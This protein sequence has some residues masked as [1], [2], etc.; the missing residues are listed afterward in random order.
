MKVHSD[1]IQGSEDWFALR[2]GKVTGSIAH[3]VQAKGRGGG[4]SLTRADEMF[5]LALEIIHNRPRPAG[6]KSADMIH[7]TETEPFARSHY[8]I[9]EGVTVKEVGFITL[10]D[11]VGCSPDGLIGD[12]GLIEI[13]CP[14]NR[15]QFDRFSAGVFPKEYK[16]QVQFLLWATGRQWCDFVSFAPDMLSM[17]YFKIRV[18]RDPEYINTL[19]IAVEKFVQELKILVETIGQSPF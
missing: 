10:G 14:K 3:T 2:L 17:K 7:G 18:Y 4:K 5:E 6:Y 19:E 15:V 8:E 11:D 1:I 13:K 12:D 16:A 9:M